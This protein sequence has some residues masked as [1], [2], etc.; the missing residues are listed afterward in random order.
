MSELFKNGKLRDTCKLQF[1]E[2]FSLLYVYLASYSDSTTPIPSTHGL[3]TKKDRYSFGSFSRDNYRIEP[4]S[5]CL[6]CMI[7]FLSCAGYSLVAEAVM[8]VENE[9]RINI[10]EFMSKKDGILVSFNKFKSILFLGN[11]GVSKMFVCI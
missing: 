2:L 7:A 10:N 3:Y 8:H 9:H 1:A 4:S 5:I 6:K 11:Y